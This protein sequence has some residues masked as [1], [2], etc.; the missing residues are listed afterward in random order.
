MSRIAQNLKN[1]ARRIETAAE[2][3][4]RD[5]R[6]VGVLAVS[7]THSIDKI[8]EAYA[9]GLTRFG[10]SYV[11]EA[12]PKIKAL[13]S[14]PLEWHFIGPIQSNKTR[15]IAAYFDWAQSVDRLKIATRLNE[16]RPVKL[17]PLN[18]C[19]QINISLETGKSGIVQQALHEFAEQLMPLRRLKLRGL[20]AIPQK[21]SDARQQRAYFAKLRRLFDDLNQEGYQLDTLSMGMTEDL[22]AAVMEGSTL[23]RIGSGLFGARGGY[24]GK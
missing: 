8:R 21:T 19:I 3:A 6:A 4:G 11:Q 9:A 5:A 14:L 7:K 15:D 13:N 1:I 17:K 16:Q 18:I 24:I 23:L 12:I 2:L 10:E 22:E 20:M